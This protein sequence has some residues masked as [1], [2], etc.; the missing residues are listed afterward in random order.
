MSNARGLWARAG[1][2]ARR[3]SRPQRHAARRASWRAGGVLLA[4]LGCLA[5][6]TAA[7]TPPFEIGGSKATDVPPIVDVEDLERYLEANG[8]DLPQGED[9]QYAWFDVVG[10]TY[11]LGTDALVVHTYADAASAQ[12]AAATVSADGRIVTRPDGERV[13]VQWPSSPHLYLRGALLVTYVGEDSQLMHLLTL[14]LGQQ[15]AGPVAPP[16]VGVE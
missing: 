13:R 6:C 15:F 1:G 16:G 7:P 9:R 5:A 12:A 11:E 2:G 10:R 8:I 4:V 14:G 3:G